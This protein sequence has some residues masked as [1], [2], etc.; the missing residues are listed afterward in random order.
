MTWSIKVHPLV[1][2]EDFKGIDSHQKLKILT[3]I[4]KKLSSNP[5]AYG[6]PLVGEFKG[7]W[8]LKT[9]KYRVIYRIV[10]DEIL[11]FV[12]K[13]GIRRDFKVYKELFKRL[14]N[15]E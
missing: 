11:V 9:G 5:K 2:K 13:I 15:I 8:K 10:E 7:Y 6:A 12:L 4:E 3:I 1:L 14:K